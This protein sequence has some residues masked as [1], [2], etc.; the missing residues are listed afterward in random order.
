MLLFLMLVSFHAV[1]FRYKVELI[2][3][4]PFLPELKAKNVF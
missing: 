3:N 2:K 1:L 4:V